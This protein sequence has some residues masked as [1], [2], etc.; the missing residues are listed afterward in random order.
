M[1][2][3]FRQSFI[4]FEKLRCRSQLSLKLQAVDGATSFIEYRLDQLNNKHT[5]IAVNSTIWF[6][7]SGYQKK[8]LVKDWIFLGPL[9]TEWRPCKI[10]AKLNG[11]HLLMPNI[12]KFHEYQTFGL[13]KIHNMSK[14]WFASNKYGLW[15]VW[16]T[17]NGSSKIFYFYLYNFSKFQM[18]IVKKNSSLFIM[19]FQD[20]YEVPLRHKYFWST[21]FRQWND[22]FK[23]LIVIRKC[24]KYGGKTIPRPVWASLWINSVKRYTVCFYCMPS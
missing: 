8:G 12:F 16:F 23:T 2:Q 18:T 10:F 20:S 13:T 22:I 15:K 1:N 21:H 6:F 17:S 5:K 7:G 9:T 11:N 19:D 3:I 4:I 14:I 24:K